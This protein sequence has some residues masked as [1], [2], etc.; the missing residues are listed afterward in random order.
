MNKL[1][2]KVLC[3]SSQTLFKQGKWNGLKTTNLDYYYKLLLENSEFRVR[4]DL[5]EDPNFKQIIPQIILRY[6][7]KYFLHRQ[8]AG[9][10]KRLNNLCPLLL[11]GHV[12]E[13]DRDDLEG[14]DLIQTATFRELD[15]EA[16]VN[17]NITNSTFYGLIY[18]ED[19]NPVNHVH[20]GLVYIFDLDSDKV[21]I[22]EKELENIGFVDLEYLNEN[23]ETLTYWSR[24]IVDLLVQSH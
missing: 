13:F 15:E 17:A 23:R 3:I 21:K 9:T 20:V 18:L 16:E 2:Q 11:G 7:G 22:R 10:E 5:E 6:Q 8:V 24:I 1:D 4:G 12:E 14:K 19:E